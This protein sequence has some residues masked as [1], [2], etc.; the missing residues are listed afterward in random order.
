MKGW[1]LRSEQLRCLRG[2]ESPV[3]G[4]TSFREKKVHRS[5]TLVQP[6][7]TTKP[8][9]PKNTDRCSSSQL[10]EIHGA[11]AV[12]G[13]SG[14]TGQTTPCRRLKHAVRSQESKERKIADAGTSVPSLLSC[15][16]RPIRRRRATAWGFH[17]SPGESLPS[18]SDRPPVP[19]PLPPH[20]SRGVRRSHAL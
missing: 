2:D 7:S 20:V 4:S 5:T 11:G 15:D 13:G 19:P 1:L 8:L 10:Q 17:Y 16:S 3:T 9:P 18:C 6:E 12:C 14:C